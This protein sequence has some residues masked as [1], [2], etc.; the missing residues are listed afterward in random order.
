MRLR[1][2]SNQPN[3]QSAGAPD[4]GD[5][6]QNNDGGEEEDEAPLEDLY[7]PQFSEFSDFGESN[8]TNDDEWVFEDETG[9]I[10]E[11]G[12]RQPLEINKGQNNK[13][14]IQNEK[15]QSDSLSSAKE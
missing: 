3:Q 13:P 15:K 5:D 14:S 8:E 6:K 9:S 2:K 10:I 12:E 11:P 4:P 1:E 7:D